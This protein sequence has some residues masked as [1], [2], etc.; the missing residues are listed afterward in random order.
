MYQ[1]GFSINSSIK[2]GAVV[3]YVQ[4]GSV[5]DNAGIKQGDVITKFGDHDIKNSSFLK[6]Y[7]YTYSVGDKVKVTIIRGTK[8]ETLNIKLTEKAN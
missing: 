2:E 1:Y 7:L 8:E 4:K 3:A 5:A 6:Y